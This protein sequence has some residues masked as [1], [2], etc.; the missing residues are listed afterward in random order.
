MSSEECMRTAPRAIRKNGDSVYSWTIMRP[1][2]SRGWE[3]LFWS[4]FGHSRN[5]MA[6][7]TESRRFA[8]VNP[9]I[10]RLLGYPR[11]ELVGRA[12]EDLLPDSE[13]PIHESDWQRFLAT[14]AFAGERDLVREDGLTVRFEFAAHTEQ[15][16]GRRLVLFVIMHAEVETSVEKRDAA[17][18]GSQSLSPREREIVEQIARGESGEEIAAR[19]G[20]SPETVRTH[21]R[22]AKEK[23]EAR[24]RAQLVAIALAQGLIHDASDEPGY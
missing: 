14:G 6:L 4:V 22:N 5:P 15:V 17:A 19:L 20:L 11:D 9:S 21:V 16:T 18:S 1:P 10:E 23:L 12:V 24:N 2:A 13:R 8:E 3:R 7:I